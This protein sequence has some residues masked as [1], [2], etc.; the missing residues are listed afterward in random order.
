[1]NRF[2]NLSTDSR[3]LLVSAVAFGAIAL[4]FFVAEGVLRLDAYVKNGLTRRS[5]Q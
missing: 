1:M 2:K 4:C 5:C 3:T